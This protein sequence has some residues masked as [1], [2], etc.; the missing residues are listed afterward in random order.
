MVV[1]YK[2]FIIMIV[3]F[4][5]AGGVA[6][7]NQEGGEVSYECELKIDF[8]G[9]RA[10]SKATIIISKDNGDI[11]SNLRNMCGRVDF[12]PGFT[13]YG[14]INRNMADVIEE[15]ERSFQRDKEL[16]YRISDLLNTTMFRLESV[17]GEVHAAMRIGRS[18]RR[19]NAWLLARSRCLSSCVLILAGG[20]RRDI[21]AARIGI[22]RPFFESYQL[23]TRDKMSSRVR[24]LN[25]ELSV[26]FEEMGQPASLLDAMRAVPPDQIQTLTSSELER[27]MLSGIDPVFDERE[28][29][30]E[31]WRYG[32]NPVEIRRRRTLS[33]TMCNAFLGTQSRPIESRALDQYKECHEGI[34]YATTTETLRS[35]T[36]RAR[37]LCTVVTAS[38]QGPSFS[39]QEATRL[40]QCRRDVMIGVR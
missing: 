29:A 31:A 33:S 23:N 39:P 15:L 26:Y 22:H 4:V 28:V 10:G 13:I 25:N 20:V 24:N 2:I 1:L 37:T 7:A 17:G 5:A 35:R 21:G 34:M 6:S 9:A 16:S 8:R 14:L 38:Q 36:E 11:V 32:S 40:Q 27:F 3:A 30:R 19:M 12:L 18:M